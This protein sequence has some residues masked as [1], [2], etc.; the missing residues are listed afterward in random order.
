[1]ACRADK[2]S[3][4]PTVISTDSGR[5]HAAMLN[6]PMAADIPYLGDEVVKP[7]VKA[8]MQFLLSI[9]SLIEKSGW[10]SQF[11]SQLQHIKFSN[12]V[13]L[14]YLENEYD[15]YNQWRRMNRFWGLGLDVDS[16]LTDQTEDSDDESETETPPPP[17]PKED[18]KLPV[19]TAAAASLIPPPPRFW[20]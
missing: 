3:E 20:G 6:N 10:R 11:I 14:P 18:V 5:R 7:M 19:V 4:L 8:V 15:V 13:V 16:H 12:G 1:M 2:T 9:H 17:P